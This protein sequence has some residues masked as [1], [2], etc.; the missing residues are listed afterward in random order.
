[1]ENARALKWLLNFFEV[2][3]GL[4]VNYDKSCVFGLN[5]DEESLV[6]MA[7][8]LGCNIGILPIPYLGLRVGAGGRINGV[9]AWN[10]VL[11]KVKGRLR[12]WEAN[13]LFLG[14]RLTV[15]KS[16]LSAILIYNLS[17]Q[18]LPKTVERNL[19]SVLPV[20]LGV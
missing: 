14:G 13:S 1:M 3:S 2:I 10:G 8:E 4:L 9:E 7:V 18:R 16:V 20:S 19:T 12:R 15:V 6:E 17:F 5:L 11:D